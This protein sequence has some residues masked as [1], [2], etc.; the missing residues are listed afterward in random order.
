MPFALEEINSYLCDL[1]PVVE[2]VLLFSIAAA[3]QCKTKNLKCAAPKK[4]CARV[5]QRG[6]P[7][8]AKILELERD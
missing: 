2:P 1:H 3:T 6:V 5:M 4:G 8:H 7:R